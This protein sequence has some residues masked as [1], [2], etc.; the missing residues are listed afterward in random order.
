MQ[1]GNDLQDVFFVRGDRRVYLSMLKDQAARFGLC[2]HGFCLMTNHVHLVAT[3]TDELSLAKAIGTTHFL[4]SQYVN[5]MHG[6]GGHLW[7]G[8]F[9]SCALDKE[10]LWQALRY[11]ERNPVRAGIVRRAWDYEWSSAAIHTGLAAAGGVVDL[12]VWGAAWR[13]SDWKRLLGRSEDKQGMSQ[14][15][16]STSRGRPLGSDSFLRKA[17]AALGRRVRALP[18]GRPRKH[19][20]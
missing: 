1:R 14:L 19:E 18:V 3:P 13:P 16:L 17:E 11:V 20:K 4:Y 7:Q 10:H 9:Y 15:R 12:A 5:R 8:R 2:I 6:R